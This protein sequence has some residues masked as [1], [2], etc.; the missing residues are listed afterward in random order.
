[1][2]QVTEKYSPTFSYFSHIECLEHK[3]G[4]LVHLYILKKTCLTP[5]NSGIPHLHTIFHY[6]TVICIDRL[7]QH[8]RNVY[9]FHNM[10]KSQ[11]PQNVTIQFCAPSSRY[12]R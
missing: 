11:N 4:T 8:Q 6:Q 9:M 3:L 7:V 12:I 10:Q 2:K 1:M 5:R